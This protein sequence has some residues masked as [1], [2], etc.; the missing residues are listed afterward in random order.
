[1]DGTRATEVL[2]LL[3]ERL[4]ILPGGRDRRG[5]PVLVF[6][7]T[8]RR[9]R[10]KPEDYR[11]L[12]QYLLTIPNDEARGLRFT[13]IVDMRGATWDSV[14]PILKVLHEHFHRSIHVAFIIKPENFWQKQRTS[15]AKQKKYNFEINT[16]S[17]EA[18][19]K[20]IDPSQ[21]TADLDGSLQYD[22]AQW[23]D[24]R[25]A[26]EDFTWQAADLLDR[27]DDLQEDLSR[28]DF[29]D[30]VA[31]AKHGI[32][33]HNEMKKKIMKVPVEEIEVV[34][35]RLLQRFDNSIAASSGEGGSIESGAT[36]GTDPDGRA[37]AALVIQHL[38]SVHA[39]QQH[40]LQLWHIKKMKLDQCFQ[41]RLF[42]QDCAKMFDWICHNREGFLANY[43]EIGRSYQLAKNLQE[44]HKHFTMSSMNVYVNINKIL[45]MASRLLETQHYAAGHVR[46]VAGRLD[47]A[48]KEFAAGLDERTAVLSLSVV[49]HHKAEQYVDSV[50]GW[51]Q[52]CDAGNLPNEIPILESHI[53]QHQT[54]YEAM[55]QAYTESQDGHGIDGH[56]GMSGNPAA[57]YSEGAS[58]VLAVIHQILGHH[59][60]LEARWHAR[61]VKLHQRLALRLFQE[62][63]KQVLDWLTNH[64]EVFI[65]KNTGVGRNLQK[66]RV[67]QKS[68]EHFENVAQNTYTN[69]TKLLTAAQELAHTGECAADEIYA[70]AQEL[71]AHVSSFA[72]RV[73][74]RRRRLDLAVVFYTHEKELTGWVDELR[75][76]LQQDEVAENLET[77]ER[78]LEQCAQHRASCMEACASTIVQGEALLRELRESTDAPDTTGSISAVEAALDRLAGLRQELEDL[79]ATRKL[80]LE[81]CLRLRVFERDALEAS[82]QLEMWAQ[83]LQGPPREGSPEQLLRVHNDGVAHMQNTAF[84][85]LQ[86]GQELA[87]VLE[88]AGVCIM[89]DGQHSAASRVQVLLEFLNER[90]M[91]A[92]DLAE[93]RRVRLEQASQLV[94]LQTDA[95][96]VANWIRNGEAMLLA[97]LRVPEN[98]QDA[99]QLRLEHEQFQ[100]AIE[101]TH[102]SAV[103]VKHRADA[104]VSANH[105]D[106]KSIREVAEDVTKRWQQLVTCAEERHKLVTAS[107]NFYKT[108]EQVRSVLDSLEREYKRDEDWCASGEKA[109]Q[110]P[111]LVGKHQEQKEAFLKA[112]TLVRRT[113]E[114]FLKYTNRSLQFYSYQAN[115]A[116]SENKVKSILEELLSKENRVLE[117]WTQRK[118]RLDQCHQYVLFERSAK[119]ALEWIRETGELYLATHT[120]VGKNRIENEQLLREHNEFKGAAKE[121]RERVKLLI[122][123]ADNLVEKGHAHAAAIKQSVAEVDQRYKD[124][125]TRMDCYKS[126]IEE[127]LGIQSDD[128][129]KDLSIDRNSDP[130][131]EEKIKGKDLKELN[132]EKRRSA[133]RKEFIM[134]ELLQTERTYVKDLETCIR[135]FLE[136]TRCGK[137]NVPS[138]LQGRESIIFSNMEEIHQFHSNIFLRELEKYETMP[139][140]VGHCF[141][142][143]A[144][145]FDMYVTYCKNKPE[146]NQLLVT[147]GGT[148]FEELQRKQRV[149]H[150]IAAYLIKPVQRITKYQLLLKDLQAC[151]QEGQ[152]EIK[153]GLEVMLNVPKKANDALHL[154]M[155]EGCDVRIDTL[156]DV[157]LQ[158]S[159][160]VWDPK[161]LIRKGRDRHIFLFELYLLFS[162]EVKDS[163]GKVK[164][165]YKS[166]LMTSELGVTEHIEGDECK[167]AVWTG[168]APTSDTRV[169]LRANS[170]DA[171]QLWVKRLR[172]VIQET[173]F[174]LSMPKSPAKKSSSQRSSRDLE[175]CASLDD[176][177]ENLDRNSLASFGSTNTTDSD[178]TGVAEV[179]WVIADHSAAPG[180]K[181]LTV[182]KG[183]QVEVLENGSNISGVNTSEWTHVRLLVAPG[184]VDPPPEGLVPTSALKQPPPVSSK[185]SPSRKVPGQQQQQQQQ[186]QQ[187]HYHQQQSTSQIQTA[188]SSGGIT[189]VSSGATGIPGSSSSVVGTGIVASGGLSSQNVP[190][191]STLPDETENII[192]GTAA[193]ATAAANDG[194][195]AAN[196]NSPGNKRRG[197]SGRKWLPPPLRKLS[198]GKVEKSPPTTTPTTTATTA[199]TS[200]AISIV[201]TSC[202]RSSLKKNVSEKRFRL[203]SG[204]EQS[205]PLRSASVS[206]SA[207]TTATASMRVSTS[208]SEADLDTELEPGLEGAEEEEGETEQSEPE[209]EEDTMPEPD[210]TE[211]LTYS[212]QNGA[213]DAEDELE[214]PPPMKPITEPILVAT[215]NG[216]SESAIAT[217]SC[218]KSRTSERSAKILDG[219]TTADLAEIE[220]IVK[221]RMEQHTENQERQSLMRTPSGKS[222]NVGIGGDD[223]YDEGTLSTAITIAGTTIAAPTTATSTTAMTTA[224]TM[225]TTMATTTTTTTTTTTSSPVHG[226][227][228]ECDVESAVLAKRQFVIRE[229][230]ET[231]KD[232]V[233]DLKQIVEGYMS[234]MRDPESEVPLP[235]DLRGGKDKMVFGNIEAIYEWHRDFFLKAL[236]R[237]LERPEELGPLFKRYERKLHMYVVYCQNKP[238]SEY[239]VSEYIDTYFEDLRQKLGHR[240]QLCDLLIKPVQRITKYQLLLREALRLT[241]RTQRMSE[242]EGLTAAVHVMRIIPK[243][244]NDMMDVARLQGFDGKITAQGKLLLHGPLLVSEFSSNLPSKEKEWQ[245]FLFEQNIIFSEAVGKKTQFTNPVYIYKAHIQVN[246]LCL[247]N[248]YDD[249]EKFIIRSTDPRKPGLAF[250][251]SAAEENGPRKQEWVDTITAILQTQHDFLKAIQ[252]PIAYQ[253]ELTKDPFRGVSPDSPCRGSVLSTISS[254]IP[255]MSKTNE[256]RRNELAGAAGSTISATSKTLA[257]AAAVAATATGTGTGTA[258]TSVLHR[259]RTGATD[260]DSPQ[261]QSS[262]SKSRLNFLEGFR[263][264]LRPRSPVRNN[265]IPIVPGSRVRLTADW[266]KLHAGEELEIFRVDGPGL[267]VSPVIGMKKEEFWI[268]A[269]LVPNSSI[270]RAW[271]FRP[272]RI[273]SAEG[274]GES[275]R[276]PQDIHAEENGPP[277]IL[278]IP[279]S[280]RATAGGVA[281]LVLEAR[282]VERA[283]VRWRK[284]GQRCDIIEGTDRYRLFRTNDSLCLE[285]APCLPSDSGIYHCLVEH[286]TGSCSA[287]IPLRII[288]ID[289][290]NAW[291]DTI[292]CNRSNGFTMNETTSSIVALP[293]S[294]KK[295][296]NDMEI[297]QFTNKYIELEELGTGR[298]ARVCC[299]R[300]KGFDREVALKQI[301]RSKQPLSL[302][303][304][305]YDLLRSIRHDNIVRAFALFEDTPQPDIDT[306]V[307]ELVRGST[308]FAYLGEQV[309]YTESTVAKYTGQLLSALQ[310]LHS[311][312]QAHLDL[313]PENI[314]VDSETGIVKLIDFGE[315]IRAVPLDQVVPPPVDLEFAAP[316]SVLG[317]PTGSYTDMWAAGVFLYVLLSGLSPFLDDSIEET[318]ANIL[319]CDF[320]F[321]DE[322]F[323]EISTDVKNLLETLLRLH[324][325]DRATAQLILSSPW[326]KISIGATIP[327]SRMVAFTERR[328]HRSKSHQDR[329][330]SFYS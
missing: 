210:D 252:S 39:A 71:E 291:C 181:E 135:C 323:N 140:D 325:E 317:K 160:T 324:G 274:S 10:A 5:G 312:K 218:G 228:E 35:Q 86:Q 101:K 62:D 163:A 269:S 214:L 32:D 17:L 44:E 297:E 87:Q 194:S 36:G 326:F 127:D 315:A 174:S 164:Y 309:E 236:E 37:L 232:Y 12:L 198:Q 296:T 330:S 53:R 193:A 46:A 314:L 144:P 165:I 171:K 242:I 67:Y 33:L 253:K 118:K 189:T 267:I 185:T 56:S 155:L 133:R 288:G 77:A 85:V 270:S 304:A 262:P 275:V 151:C 299:A 93:M 156:G 96:H 7:T 271:S 29:A 97:S 224:A 313:K 81:L 123:L 254:T 88:Q 203:P 239:I 1:M 240:L 282:R 94:Q 57:D 172:E 292:E 25:L 80:R 215:A 9:E 321:P 295:L 52:A 130:L 106:P 116:G 121:T 301:S 114:T 318:T 41:L 61:K 230:V 129:Q 259:P 238:V 13:V 24:T 284:E 126:Q 258:T 157:V 153:D 206:I 143:W 287:K 38:E 209:L 247:Q 146:S 170:M 216:S 122:Q 139:E 249:P 27:L 231:E 184:Q 59:R 278:T 178:K 204:G 2:P 246:K 150:P 211:A 316:E 105:Y 190:P 54:L 195:G 63:V 223:D 108:A 136:E 265:S 248:S 233:N 290:T 222:S 40:L 328:A 286:E 51:S 69:A 255:N 90:E 18:L 109:T 16:I 65:R 192:V 234:L 30:D 320:C 251:C 166:R 72:A 197:F 55:C 201:Q 202:E 196:T 125:S 128:G 244:A 148:W 23:I 281:R 8:A 302:T 179:T 45:T 141:V 47:R 311:R 64:G 177:V 263:S 310:W 191:S 4:A 78:L 208:V 285:I 173:Y 58:H 117:Y 34:G 289:A 113:A 3:Q 294:K 303:R 322:Y 82:G 119:Q 241:E 22:H 83:E 6:P 152:G 137:G 183:Q 50:A 26:V 20:V 266:G 176:S 260:Q 250:S 217:E 219:A 14:K 188:A 31:G 205:R 327:S 280:I 169:V 66:A 175:E 237:C 225:V 283:L 245:V 226:T 103:Q 182:T 76:E 298:F 277:A 235:D 43:V 158:D 115:S 256:E 329:N 199:T 92:E 19:T 74:Q 305:E 84:Q 147:H 186:Q 70:V 220:Q 15:L 107:I 132:E 257:T 200:T 145:K 120:N 306:I 293:N 21:L 180:S 227:S 272:R 60:A 102:T 168:R 261:T 162:K 149:E 100:V 212:E 161:Q 308:L 79:W 268:P 213:D 124:F 28:N 167:F 154:S 229:L 276:L 273:D 221:E 243:A 110:V 99:E 264:T 159:F 75:Q 134:A 131:L 300:E 111:T 42:E 11:R 68:H 319:K 104:L 207:L 95:T 279:C 73:E 307:L 48:W 112:C 89:A 98:L 138:G 187:S 49:F 91:D 142:T